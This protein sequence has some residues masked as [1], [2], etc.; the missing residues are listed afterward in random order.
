MKIGFDRQNTVDLF[1]ANGVDPASV[2]DSTRKVNGYARGVRVAQ[3]TSPQSTVVKAAQQL[4]T[5]GR[6]HGLGRDQLIQ[7]IQELT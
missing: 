2:P 6:A 3:S 5:V 1:V 4:I 7:L